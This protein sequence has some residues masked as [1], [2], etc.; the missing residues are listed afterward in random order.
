MQLLHLYKDE[1]YRDSWAILDIDL[2]KS[3]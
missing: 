2:R 1:Q 3:A